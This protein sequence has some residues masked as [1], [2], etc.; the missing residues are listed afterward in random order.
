MK[1]SLKTGMIEATRLTRAGR[2]SEAMAAIRRSLAGGT[3]AAAEIG[4]RVERPEA[5]ATTGII[6]MVA[7]SREAE[8]AWTSPPAQ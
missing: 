1:Y 8:G 7:P 3:A 5:R 6:D 4:P 2:L